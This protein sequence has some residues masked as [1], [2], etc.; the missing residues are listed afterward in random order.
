MTQQFYGQNRE[1]MNK[2]KASL[3]GK[4]PLVKVEITFSPSLPLI[5]K[6]M[7]SLVGV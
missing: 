2:W 7:Y 4:L 6:Q 1:T 3:E 5:L